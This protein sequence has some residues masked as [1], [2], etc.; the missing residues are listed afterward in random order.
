MKAVLNNIMIPI[1]R[2]Q[3]NSIKDELIKKGIDISNIVNIEYLKRSIDSRKK[4]QIKFLYNLELTFKKPIDIDNHKYLTHPKKLKIES[5]TS[6]KLKGNIAII[7]SGPA[8]LF[9]ALRLCEYGYTPIIFERGKKVEDRDKSID[10]FY[11][12]DDLDINSNIQFGEGG[13]GTYSDGKLNTRVKSEYITKVFET[14]VKLGAQPEIMWDYKPHI[15]TDILKVVVKNLRE[16]IISMGGKFYFNTLVEDLIIKENKITGIKIKKLDDS[17]PSTE[18]IE[19]D[20]L[21]LA[22]GHSARDTYRML[23]KNGVFME[24]KPFA[25]GTR[26]EHKREIIDKMQYG[27]FANHPNLE[28]ATYS[29]TYNNKNEN[30]GV[31]SFCMCPGGVIVNAASE[32]NTSL[33][34]GMSY[35]KRDGEFSNSAI[36]VGIKANEFGE[37]LFSGME[38]Q[39]KLEKSAYNNIGNYGG[40]AQRVT[41]FIKNKTSTSLPKSSYPMRMKSHNLNDFF[42]EVINKN[43]KL[44]FNRWKNMSNFISHD[45]LL[46][47]PETRTSAPVKITRNE[48]GE[49]IN[50]KGLYPIGEGAG[51][52]GGITSAA[53]DG[54]KII[55][56]IFA[57]K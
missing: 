15:G 29:M 7:G 51:Y 42:P 9:A 39:E 36:A 31:F 6:K 44:A 46:I 14:L 24:N 45:A 21:V 23:D 55:D 3:D 47:G 17:N 32:K 52:A 12:K 34:N 2:D 11:S 37:H 25:M 20:H 38:M 28:A 48:L 40:V 4:S 50:I 56:N 53:I 49:S 19:V 33:V 54:L 26:I 35:S 57:T 1:E 27:K 18:I 10:N 22:I 8:G 43:M 5:R 16:T 30:R 41:D 13:A